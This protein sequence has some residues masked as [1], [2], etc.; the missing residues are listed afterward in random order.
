MST[1]IDELSKTASPSFSELPIE[2]V[3]EVLNKLD[4]I[5]RLIAWKVSSKFQKI[6]MVMEP[7]FKEIK[8][9]FIERNVH[10]IL[11][12]NVLQYKPTKTGCIVKRNNHFSSL[13]N[14]DYIETAIRDLR[15]IFKRPKLELHLFSVIIEILYKKEERD[16]LY[17]FLTEL[18]RRVEPINTKTISFTRMHCEEMKSILSLLNA[19]NIEKIELN[20]H[21]GILL[22]N[23][24]AQLE[25][26]KNA[27][28]LCASAVFAG[29]YTSIE[30]LFNF[31]KFEINLETFTVADAVKIKNILLNSANFNY[32]KIEYSMQFVA[33]RFEVA[34]LFQPSNTNGNLDYFAYKC[35]G[36]NYIIFLDDYHLEIQRENDE[37]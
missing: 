6:L 2:L 32:C 21:H 31:R 11:D 15:L 30:N 29:F 7:G 25:Q 1:S 23:Y 18:M 34:R 28:E 10:L 20:F 35:S 17:M 36:G 16:R 5:D 8:V 3:G 33:H 26:W 37:S 14:H 12:G 27:K 22:E 4:P 19:N 13:K 9:D 24:L